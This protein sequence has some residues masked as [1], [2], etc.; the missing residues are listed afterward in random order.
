MLLAVLPHLLHLPTSA[1]SVL[2][3]GLAVSNSACVVCVAVVCVPAVLHLQ[4]QANSIPA[5]SLRDVPIGSAS[6]QQQLL[7]LAKLAHLAG[8]DSRI[9]ADSN[10][11][12]AATAAA[13][14]AEAS[15]SHPVSYGT[16][17]D[18][19]RQHRQCK[20]DSAEQRQ[21]QHSQGTR[22]QEQQDDRQTNAAVAAAALSHVTQLRL[23]LSGKVTAMLKAEFEELWL[24][25][26]SS[27]PPWRDIDFLH[28]L[29]KHWGSVL[30][31]TE[32]HMNC[33]PTYAAGWQ[34]PLQLEN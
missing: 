33:K 7:L 20:R 22:Q 9:F 32:N 6:Q 34:R 2:Y 14:A 3:C 19:G 4:A 30:Q 1:L 24:D 29:H 23:G 28:V 25:V 10:V 26:V 8:M 5:A 16:A 31:V 21:Q 27:K 17:A 11:A 15:E 12:E 13:G 18:S